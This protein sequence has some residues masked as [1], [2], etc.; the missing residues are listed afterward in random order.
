MNVIFNVYEATLS[1][2]ASWFVFPFESGPSLVDL[3]VN[4]SLSSRI[5]QISCGRS[6]SAVLMD[7][8]EGNVHLRHWQAER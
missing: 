1:E 2:Q 5:Q 7:N 6:H 4:A 8:G 3:G